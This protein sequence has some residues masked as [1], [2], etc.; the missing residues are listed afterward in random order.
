LD[1]W[2]E[3]FDCLNDAVIV[4]SPSLDPLAVNAAAEA[5]LEAS[6]VD[7][8]KVG[9]LMRR[10]PWLRRMLDLCL[11]SGQSLD[12][13]EAVLTL[14][15][16]SIAVHAEIS[17]LISRTGHFEGAIVVFH[18][19]SHQKSAEQ[20]FDPDEKSFRL[21]P[22]GLAHEVKNPL[23]G[24]KGA[25]ELL[26]G[27][28]PDDDRAKLYCGLILDGVN[29]IAGLV[30]QVLA[31]TNPQ[32]LKRESFNIHQVLHQAL[33]MA[34]LMLSTTEDVTI[35]QD[36]DPSL[37]EVHGDPGAL[38]RVFL[39]LLRNARE[40]IEAADFEGALSVRA[41]RPAGEVNAGAPKM[42]AE[43]GRGRIRLRTAIENQF[44]ISAHGG[45]RRQFLRVEVSDTGGGMSA[46]ELKQLFTPFYTTKPSGTGL[47][48]VLSQRIVALH[49]GKLWAERGSM[50]PRGAVRPG[51]TAGGASSN[52][53]SG[54]VTA[55][56]NLTNQAEAEDVRPRGM[57]FCVMLPVG[58]D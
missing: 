18:D 14:N 29:R 13:P 31:A 25:A 32:R 40:A 19:L 5:I 21:S 46:A 45:K 50:L 7:R 56:E 1:L 57:T 6:Q 26:S 33:R 44:R 54:E 16:R 30:E 36:F 53:A 38:E 51:R 17:P 49:G 22:A 41:K 20:A 37:P 27:M 8:S 58:P 15:H 9:R 2:H 3:I 11:H 48:L 28:F 4:L 34:G 24:I 10:N 55:S 35:E 52:A 43:P 12:N 23:T 47:G 42:T 39:N